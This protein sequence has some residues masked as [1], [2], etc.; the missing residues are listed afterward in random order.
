MVRK[1][2]NKFLKILFTKGLCVIMCTYY[3]HNLGSHLEFLLVFHFA[4]FLFFL[5]PIL[6]QTQS[7]FDKARYYL[8]LFADRKL[9]SVT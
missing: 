8:I 4:T 6:A 3:F 5:N 9:P 7:L 2:S 1:D